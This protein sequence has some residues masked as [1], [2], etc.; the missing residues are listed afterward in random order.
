VRA[1]APLVRRPNERAG[2]GCT[3]NTRTSI[4]EQG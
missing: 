4:A 3:V 1:C 2:L